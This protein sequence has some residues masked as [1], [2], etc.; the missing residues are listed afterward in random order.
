MKPQMPESSVLLD[1]G[2][3]NI[4]NNFG[5]YVADRFARPPLR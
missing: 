2:F 5:L 3:Y 4:L 1:R